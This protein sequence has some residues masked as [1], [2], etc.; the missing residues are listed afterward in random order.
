M[1]AKL[2]GSDEVIIEAPVERVWKL[3]ADSSELVNWGPPVRKVEVLAPHD[4]AEGLNSRRRV[5][6]E[7][8]GKTGEFV[9]RRIDHAEQRRIEYRIEEETFGLFRVMSEPGFS[10]EIEPAGH[11][12]TRLVWRF[13]HN[14]KGI[15]GAILNVVVIRRQQ[16]R[17][18]LAGLESLKRYAETGTTG[19]KRVFRPW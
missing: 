13:F 2:Q 19:E 7:F 18:R 5:S 6:A 12:R 11:G 4:Q 9:E 15:L 1:T 16:R 17:N 3:I 10:M 14:P 8:G